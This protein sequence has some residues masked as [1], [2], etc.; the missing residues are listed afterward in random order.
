MSFDASAYRSL[1]VAKNKGHDRSAAPLSLSL[2]LCRAGMQFISSFQNYLLCLSFGF[3]RP[4]CSPSTI[5]TSTRG[6]GASSRIMD[7]YVQWKR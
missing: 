1:S 5:R 7:G 4:F 3:V 2:F 6:V